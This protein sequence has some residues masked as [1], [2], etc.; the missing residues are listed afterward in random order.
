MASSAALELR[1]CYPVMD[2]KCLA[3]AVS[4]EGFT[5]EHC[6]PNTLYYRVVKLSDESLKMECIYTAEKIRRGVWKFVSDFGMGLPYE[7]KEKCTFFVTCTI[8]N[9]SDVDAEIQKKILPKVKEW[10]AQPLAN[11][12]H[13]FEC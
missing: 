6:H 5:V 1:K 8:E 9:L 7:D 4:H 10:L 13:I 11:K 2:C 3:K 12:D